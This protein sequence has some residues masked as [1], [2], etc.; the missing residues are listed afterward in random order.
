MPDT[1]TNDTGTNDTGTIVDLVERL[2]THTAR[3]RAA[4]ALTT[5][6]V[7]GAAVSTQGVSTDDGSADATVLLAVAAT[8]LGEQLEAIEARRPHIP[9]VA[10]AIETAEAATGAS[11]DGAVTP[12]GLV[13]ELVA[14]ALPALANG[15]REHL[16]TI[17]VSVDAP[18]VRMLNNALRDVDEI[19]S[20]AALLMGATATSPTTGPT[21]RS[22][23]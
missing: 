3:V 8:R 17:D 13:R 21:N 2:D 12:W 18:T 7:G 5:P 9:T 6:V 1:G 15:Y 4:L 10:A 11:S 16:G 22:G 20:D 14:A 19:A 23:T